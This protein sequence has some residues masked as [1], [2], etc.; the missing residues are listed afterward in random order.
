MQDGAADDTAGLAGL[1]VKRPPARARCSVAARSCG[2]IHKR[3]NG[4]GCLLDE[5][6]GATDRK[7]AKAFN[8]TDP[9]RGKR[10]AEGTARQLEAKYPS[11]AASL[12]EG[13]DDMFAV[14][15]LGVSDRLARSLS[16]TNKHRVDDL[17]RAH[18]HGASEAMD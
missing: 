5:F 11:A 18:D 14:R 4:A 16:C 7:L 1:T 10:V 13:L 8:D 3:R 9:A 2:V 6:A 15:R 17:G 12:R